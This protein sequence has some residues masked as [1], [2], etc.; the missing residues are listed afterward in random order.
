MAEPK[1]NTYPM[2]NNGKCVCCCDERVEYIYH[3][4]VKPNVRPMLTK[5]CLTNFLGCCYISIER[6]ILLKEA[7][8]SS[9]DKSDF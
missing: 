6:P 3:G 9:I 5:E 2:E 4:T 8:H 7:K 1:K